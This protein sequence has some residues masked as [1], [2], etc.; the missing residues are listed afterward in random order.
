MLF[1]P[2]VGLSAVVQSDVDAS[3]N[4]KILMQTS[5]F[6]LVRQG[7]FIRDP[8]WIPGKIRSVQCACKRNRGAFATLENN[9]CL[10]TGFHVNQRLQTRYL[11]VFQ[12]QGMSRVTYVNNSEG[13]LLD[14][15]DRLEVLRGRTPFWSGMCCAL[16]GGDSA[17]IYVNF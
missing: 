12:S 8:S 10:R 4:C 16:R 7:I 5:R 6:F 1:S 3:S 13:L 2:A 14:Y 15:S 11:I 17:V 9:S